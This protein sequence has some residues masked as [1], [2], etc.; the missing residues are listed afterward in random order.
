M[1][2]YE[3]D[4]LQ[5]KDGWIAKSARPRL[6][7]FGRTPEEAVSDL[8]RGIAIYREALARYSPTGAYSP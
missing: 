4:V 7:G 3:V 5:V 1:E 6:A 8:G 2:T